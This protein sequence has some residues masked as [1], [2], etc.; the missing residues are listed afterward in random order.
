MRFLARVA[1]SASLLIGVGLAQV[2]VTTYHNNNL[3]T[4]FNGSETQLKPSNVDSAHFG[5]LF[6]LPTDG[7][8]YAQP[9][10]LPKIA[11]PNKG[12]HNVLYVATEH[13]SVYAFD[14][15][16]NTGANGTPL[17]HVNLGAS[18]PNGDTGTDDINPEVGITGTPVINADTGTMYLVAKTKE[19]Q[20]GNTAYVQRLHALDVATGAEKFN[21]PV[22]ISGTVNGTGEGNDGSGHVPF[23]P[24]IQHNRGGLL[25]LKLGTAGTPK[26]RIFIPFASHG[27]NGPYHGWIFAYDAET[28][29][30]TAIFNSTPNALNDPTGYPIAA[31]GIWQAGAGFASD[32]SYIYAATGN[33]SFDPATKGYGD[34]IIKVDA[35][36]GLALSD[37]FAPSNQDALNRADADLG[38]GGVM[39]LPSGYGS[40]S[41]PGLLVQ[42]GKEGTVYALNRGHLG[43]FHATDQV[44]SEFVS[45]IGGVFG[46]PAFF[47]G[48]I[49]FGSSGGVSSFDV[50]NGVVTG[51]IQTSPESYG[52][53]GPSPAVSA[54]GLTN[55]IV[56]AVQTD[57][58]NSSGPPVLRA[59]DALNLT[60]ELYAS[61]T[62]SGRD[63]FSRAVKFV[64]ATITNGKVYVGAHD[65]VGVFGHGQWVA[66]PSI[67]PPSGSYPSSV[68]VTLTKSIPSESIYYTLDGSAPTTSSHLYTAPFTLTTSAVIMAR[69]FAAGYSPSAAVQGNYLV[70]VVIGTGD[71]LT[72]KYYN[73]TMNPSFSLPPT[74]TRIDPTVDFFW[75]AGSPISGVGTTNWSARWVG[76]VQAETTGTYT[77]YTRSDDGV[78]LYVNGQLIIDNWT[79]HGQTIDS[80]RFNMVA[81]QKYPIV[82]TYYQN[83]GSSVAQLSWSALALPMQIIPQTQLYSQ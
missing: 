24:Q 62:T 81:G 57:G 26:N 54:S 10:Y 52:F 14:A 34:A 48:H 29:Q 67:S 20:G 42:A 70:N 45:A 44:V 46:T 31:G 53:P 35:R 63:T 41:A 27:D 36:T 55:G 82:M 66:A 28:L 43:G 25:L 22:V 38:S 59:Y 15:D 76:K 3:R 78:R 30:Q 74:A 23:N 47:N 40:Q 9:L 83:A 2:A 12:V 19:I 64:A 13:N 16:S 79:D 6:T 8:V 49:Y 71:G 21:G 4:G 39:I 32:G 37:F 61:D 75:G 56:W 58:Y 33:G 68:V 17:W 72:G 73:G 11:I 7:E 51:P 65:A 18:V 5:L 80:H 77:F 50:A 69:G 1:I 60:N